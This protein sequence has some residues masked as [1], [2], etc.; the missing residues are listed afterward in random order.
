V[1]IRSRRK[2]P[3]PAQREYWEQLKAGG[4][5]RYIL[6]V[7]VMRW[8]WQHAHFDDGAGLDPQNDTSTYSNR[9]RFRDRAEPAG[10]AIGRIRLGA[11]H[12]A[13]VREEIF[14]VRRRVYGPEIAGESP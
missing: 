11:F 4:K 5:K 1:K 3:S 2:L 14:R 9:L 6:R 13:G 12:V 10:V 8:G 7:G